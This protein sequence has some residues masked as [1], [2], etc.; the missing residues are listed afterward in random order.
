MRSR[1]AVVATVVSLFFLFSYLLLPSSPNSQ[2]L[3]NGAAVKEHSPELA[4]G[5]VPKQL[6]HGDTIMPKLG[7]ET[8]KQELGRA[9]WKLLHTTLARFPIKPTADEREALNSYLHLF[10]RLYPCGECATHFRAL[11]HKYP[12]QTS[13]RDAASQW[14]CFVH[15]QV[16]ERLG[17]QLFDCGQVTEAYKC[18]C[19][20]ADAE[21][22]AAEKIDVKAGKRKLVD[23]ES[24][25]DVLE[26]KVRGLGVEL[27]KDGYDLPTRPF[28][29]QLANPRFSG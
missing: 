15:N 16:N 13:S 4:S 9:S 18:G 2:S 27:H 8:I 23:A 10:A 3:R 11:L 19:A 17:K 29:K 20:D 26:E 7:N 12:P 5:S 14:G 1:V 6:L 22:E 28:P 24:G 25:V 21:D